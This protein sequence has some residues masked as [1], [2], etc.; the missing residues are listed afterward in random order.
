MWASTVKHACRQAARL[1]GMPNRRTDY[2]P[3]ALPSWVIATCDL[4]RGGEN[5]RFAGGDARREQL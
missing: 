5:V 2:W 3:Y 4:P 1:G